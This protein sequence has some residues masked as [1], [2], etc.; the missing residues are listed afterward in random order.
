[1][2]YFEKLRWKNFLSTGNAF[3]EVDFTR[4]PSTLIVG[5]NGAGKSTFLDALCFGLFNK[6]FRNIN[7]PQLVNSI[8]QKGLLVE[9]EFRVGKSQYKVMRGVKPNFFEV[10]RDGTMIDQDAALKDT[11]KYLEESILNLNYKS[12]TQIVIL[13]SASFTPFMQL[14]AHIRREVI[15]DILDIQIFTTMNGLL[16]QQLTGIQGEIRDIESK[17]EVAKQLM[18][19]DDAALLEKLKAEVNEFMSQFVLYPEL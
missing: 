19:P 10:H 11:Q 18:N 2:I 16:K 7:K 17:V 12:F 9:V 14:P 13:G 6:P 1:M 8:N 4:S 3:T 5:D 15:E